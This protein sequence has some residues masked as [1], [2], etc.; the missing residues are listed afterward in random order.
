MSSF[1][2]AFD[3]GSSDSGS[4]DLPTDYDSMMIAPAYNA[5]ARIFSNS[6]GGDGKLLII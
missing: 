1:H 3:V 5:G 2:Q 6:W 4:L